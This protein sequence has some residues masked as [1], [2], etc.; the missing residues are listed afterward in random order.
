LGDDFEF[1]GG[2]GGGGHDCGK[3]KLLVKRLVPEIELKIVVKR[4]CRGVAW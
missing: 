1:F 2:E 3:G 4:C